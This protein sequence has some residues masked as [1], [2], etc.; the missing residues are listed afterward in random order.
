MANNKVQLSNGMVIM[1]ITPTTATASDVAS[2][3]V[4]FTADGT[5]TTGTAS[6]GG[7]SKNVQIAAGVNR[8][9]SSSYTAVSGQSITVAETGT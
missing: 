8:V 7:T 6:G 3:K 9:A 5:Q 2:G 4:F 1:D